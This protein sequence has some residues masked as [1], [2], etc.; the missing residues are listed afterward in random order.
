MS[1]L[2]TSTKDIPNYEEVY[3]VYS[4]LCQWDC[5]SF[6]EP[7]YGEVVAT[8]KYWD[9]HGTVLEKMFLEHLKEYWD[10][11]LVLYARSRFAFYRREGE[12]KKKNGMKEKKVMSQTEYY[13]ALY[14]QWIHQY[15]SH[16]CFLEVVN[17]CN[18]MV[19]PKKPESDDD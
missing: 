16:P 4:R 6:E 10:G 15:K 12:P 8:T 19:L 11:K 7:S 1:T 5:R 13:G 3:K 2:E 9:Q 17:K 14:R 18:W